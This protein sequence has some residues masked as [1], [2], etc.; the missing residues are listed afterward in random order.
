MDDSSMQ[1]ANI[2]ARILVY[3]VAWWLPCVLSIVKGVKKRR[4]GL[5][6][7]LGIV[8]FVTGLLWVFLGVVFGW[9]GF[10]VMC[11]FKPRENQQAS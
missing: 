4:A 2:A 8:G 3:A 9:L 7:F 5:G 11:C 1:A 6:V 10:I